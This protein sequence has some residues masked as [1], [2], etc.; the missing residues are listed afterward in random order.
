M[1]SGPA[2]VPGFY[3]APIERRMKKGRCRST[4]MSSPDQFPL[5]RRDYFDNGK[6]RCQEPL[7]GQTKVSGTVVLGFFVRTASAPKD[8]RQVEPLGRLIHSRSTT[9]GRA[10]FWLRKRESTKEP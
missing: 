9:R 3:F 10:A 5:D 7:F 1:N 2:N 6:Q 4:A 8:G